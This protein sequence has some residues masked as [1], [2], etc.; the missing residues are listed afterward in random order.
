MSKHRKTWNSSEKLEII[1]Y[2]K[3]HGLAKTKKEF[4]VS[5]A[6]IYK[7]DALYESD[8]QAGLEGKRPTD[9]SAMQ[10]ELRKLRRENDQLKKLVAEK[11]LALRIKDEMLKK[12][13]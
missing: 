4:E 10:T 12:S 5:S 2:Y 6:S 7:W 3:Q 1:N 9:N 13:R 11:E 8:G